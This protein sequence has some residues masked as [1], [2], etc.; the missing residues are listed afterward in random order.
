MV[1]L[2]IL[3]NYYDHWK[4]H[5]TY[6]N[7]MKNEDIGLGIPMSCTII[8]PACQKAFTVD[9][10]F[11]CESNDKWMLLPKSCVAETPLKFSCESCIIDKDY[12]GSVMA[13]VD[14]TSDKDFSLTFEKCYFQIVGF[15]GV[16]PTFELTENIS[17]TLRGEGGFGS[18]S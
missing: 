2:K 3:P 17:E 15:D 11:K 12:T 5:N 4:K 7:A 16:L 13:K 1:H 10:G 9:L 6:E 18:T 8:V 14:N